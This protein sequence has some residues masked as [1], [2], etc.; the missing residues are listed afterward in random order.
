MWTQIKPTIENQNNIKGKIAW[1]I[2]KWFFPDAK[3]EETWLTVGHTVF[4]P[5]S[6]F[7]MLG[8]MMAHESVHAGQQR[9]WLRAIPWWIRYIASPKFRYSQEL[10]AYQAHF[11]F[12]KE[13]YPDKNGQNRIKIAIAKIMAS[14]QYKGMVD[15][16]TAANDLK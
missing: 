1:F 14:P 7:H 2:L 10:Q 16:T 4:M 15:A 12:L 6:Q 9:N 3:K 11:N 13:R 8:E 5:P